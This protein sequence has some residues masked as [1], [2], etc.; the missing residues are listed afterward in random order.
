MTK[1]GKDTKP[2]DT[3]STALSEAEASRAAASSA[4]TSV[5]DISPALTL[6]KMPDDMVLSIAEQASS[7]KDLLHYLSTHRLLR[8]LA[9]RP[10]NKAALLQYY[11]PSYDKHREE[12][13]GTTTSLSH[14]LQ[15]ADKTHYFHRQL[16]AKHIKDAAT[17]FQLIHLFAA[18]QWGEP[19]RFFKALRNITTPTRDSLT[20]Y[21]DRHGDNVFQLLH[22]SMT[23]AKEEEKKPYQAIFKE[24]FEILLTEKPEHVNSTQFH[25]LLGALCNQTKP[26]D[27]NNLISN[28]N[29]AEQIKTIMEAAVL[30]DR[31][32]LIH[33]LLQKE[34]IPEEEI[35]NYFVEAIDGGSAQVVGALLRYVADRDRDGA[36]EMIERET[37]S[38]LADH[39]ITPLQRAALQGYTAV[40]QALIN[41]AKEEDGKEKEEGEESANLLVDLL[42]Q[43]HQGQTAFHC[44]AKKGHLGVVRILCDAA[45]EQARILSMKKDT[46]LGETPF[47]LA[48]IGNHAEVVRF[49]CAEAGTQAKECLLARNNERTTAL[50]WAINNQGIATVRMLCTAA[51]AHHCLKELLIPTHTPPLLSAIATPGVGQTKIIQILCAAATAEHFLKEFLAARGTR[52]GKTALHLAVGLNRA[53][54]VQVL[55]ATAGEYL[56]DLLLIKNNEG[57]TALP[58]GDNNEH[59]KAVETILRSKS[60]E[61][62]LKTAYSLFSSG[63]CPLEIMARTL[64]AKMGR[65]RAET[66]LLFMPKQAAADTSTS[67]PKGPRSS[68]G[69]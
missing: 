68:S 56:T 40:T 52:E 48:A 39:T 65:A 1:P 55:C 69:S 22:R 47:S 59:L 49:L 18:A 28:R 11:F 41:W 10:E 63:T 35:G 32:D 51:T 42:N 16:S 25:T 27:L 17:R 33:F 44:A 19:E 54:A 34:L 62:I 43:H 53:D 50:A 4:D 21:R 3:A 57:K 23:Q 6:L 58:L 26:C 46:L 5:G 66:M 9:N 15:E 45:G 12:T 14:H 29:A 2:K 67:H 13:P 7:F 64:F 31:A 20:L 24:L 38:A 36:C 30:C 60:E 8:E 61:E 37:Y